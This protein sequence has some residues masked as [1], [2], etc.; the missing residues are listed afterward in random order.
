MVAPAPATLCLTGWRCV[1][2]DVRDNDFDER[3]KR[4]L[5]EAAGKYMAV[6]V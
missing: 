1:T 4:D 6:H 2:Q 3:T 5:R